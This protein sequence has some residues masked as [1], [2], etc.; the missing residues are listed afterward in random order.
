MVGSGLFTVNLLLLST[1]RG[2]FLDRYQTNVVSAR[3]ERDSDD[4]EEDDDDEE[5]EEGEV[6]DENEAAKEGKSAEEEAGKKKGEGDQAGTNDESDSVQ[7]RT[8][9]GALSCCC[10]PERSGAVSLML[11]YVVQMY[12]DTRALAWR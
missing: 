3:G 1:N 11:H 4:D 9:G 8:A 5:E 2:L 12:E 10:A 7:V 6:D